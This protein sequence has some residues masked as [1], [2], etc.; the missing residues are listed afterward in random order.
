MA[1]DGRSSEAARAGRGGILWGLASFAAMATLVP[2]IRLAVL[3]DRFGVDVPYYDEWPLVGLLRRLREDDLLI[4]HLAQQ[5]SVHR[6]FFPRVVLLTVAHYT[7]WNV[8][9]ELAVNFALAVLLMAVLAVPLVQLA[10]RTGSA[11]AWLLLP[12]MSVV[13]FSLAQYENWLWGWQ[14]QIFMAAI[15][16]CGALFLL[17]GAAP[18]FIRLF[19]AGALGIV[20][21]FSF[22]NGLLV[23]PLGFIALVLSSRPF[24]GRKAWML[25]VW[26]A[27]AA[28][29][30][31]AYFYTFEMPPRVD[32]AEPGWSRP[33]NVG[34]CYLVY[35]GAAF[36]SMNLDRAIWI[37]AIGLLAAA[38]LMAWCATRGRDR[39][40]TWLPGLMLMAF[41]LGSGVLIVAGRA[42]YGVQQALAS[43]YITVSNLFWIG[44]LTSASSVVLDRIDL[45]AHRR[46]VARQLAAALL[47]VCMGASSIQTDA[48]GFD[49]MR[50]ISHLQRVLRFQLLQGDRSAQMERLYPNV[51]WLH[52]YKEVA[53][54]KGLWAWRPGAPPELFEPPPAS[55]K[56]L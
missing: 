53:R 14:C 39:I 45:V 37:G 54:R 43:R 24:T 28:A 47:A 16:V 35:V 31:F 25:G 12:A 44:L 2:P 13:I 15:G 23:W 42:D 33:A 8:R 17:C 41:G 34:K 4:S 52:W 1:D 9:W 22:A 29:T 5:H 51:K 11:A 55:Y 36:A 10:R 50:Q 3:L 19:A 20:A 38:V 32:T 48:R 49:A 40:R 26:I 6:V 46:K 21:S 56:D 27:I 18:G 30:L 7:G